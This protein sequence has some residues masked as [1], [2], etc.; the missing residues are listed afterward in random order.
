MEKVLPFA[1]DY[2]MEAPFIQQHA[3]VLSQQLQI[4]YPQVK[5]KELYKQMFARINVDPKFI[6]MQKDTS[7]QHLPVT[8]FQSCQKSFSRCTLYKDFETFFSVNFENELQKLSEIAKKFN[9]TIFWQHEEK[10]QAVVG[11]IIE[12]KDF[13]MLMRLCA[14]E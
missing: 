5:N 3:Q 10:A 2:M 14:L 6:I 11:L 7:Q 4:L 8:C 1:F 9:D 12:Q 13:G